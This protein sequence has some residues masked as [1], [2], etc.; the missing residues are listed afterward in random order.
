M[1]WHQYWR[2]YYKTTWPSLLNIG[3]L[4]ETDRPVKTLMFPYQVSDFCWGSFECIYRH[5]REQ[6]LYVSVSERFMFDVVFTNRKVFCFFPYKKPFIYYGVSSLRRRLSHCFTL[7]L[8]QTV[9]LFRSQTVYWRHEIISY[10]VPVCIIFLYKFPRLQSYQRK[11]EWS[12]VF[13]V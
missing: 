4:M 7:L 6:K 12:A 2:R 9:D 5:N 8:A 13:I 1:Q 3:S 10:Y 11:V